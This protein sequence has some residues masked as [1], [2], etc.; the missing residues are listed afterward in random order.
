[1]LLLHG[2]AYL[3]KQDINVAYGVHSLGRAL[4]TYVSSILH[5]IAKARQQEG[6]L[7]LKGFSAL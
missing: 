5:S 3:V 2:W 7:Q 1:M 4:M 6:N